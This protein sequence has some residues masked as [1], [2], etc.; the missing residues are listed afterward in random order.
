MTKILR[1]I[2]DTGLKLLMMRSG[3]V[4][5]LW[6]T[7]STVHIVLQE[8]IVAQLISK[9]LVLYGTHRFIIVFTKARYWTI[10]EASWIRSTPLHTIS[11]RHILI[12][13][14]HLRLRFLSGF[15]LHVFHLKCYAFLTHAYSTSHSSQPPWFHKIWM[16]CTCNLLLHPVCQ[17]QI[18]SI[19][20][21][22]MTVWIRSG[23]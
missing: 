5:F 10:S 23:R 9:L 20:M 12:L 17:V 16:S 22:V 3:D 19:M 18:F 13:S 2:L 7:N 8:L 15:S 14:F 21:T 6:M 11:P 4:Q 1:W